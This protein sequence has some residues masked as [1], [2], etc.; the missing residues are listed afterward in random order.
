MT[1]P[2]WMSAELYRKKIKLYGFYPRFPVRKKLPRWDRGF[3]T[4]KKIKDI[5][6]MDIHTLFYLESHCLTSPSFLPVL[7]DFV[8]ARRKLTEFQ[9]GSSRLL[10]VYLAGVHKIGIPLLSSLEEKT[11]TTAGKRPCLPVPFAFI[12]AVEILKEVKEE[13]LDILRDPACA[14]AFIKFSGYVS[15]VVNK[16]LGDAGRKFIEDTIKFFFFLYPSSYLLS[17]P[18]KS[19]YILLYYPHLRLL[20]RYAI[21]QGYY[22][23][24]SRYLRNG[25]FETIINLINATRLRIMDF[26]LIKNPKTFPLLYY[27]KTKNIRLDEIIKIL[28][29][30]EPILPDVVGEYEIEFFRVALRIT[31]SPK[32]LLRLWLCFHFLFH[33]TCREN[34][35]KELVDEKLNDILLSLGLYPDFVPPG[36]SRKVVE[37][38]IKEGDNEIL[39]TM[40]EYAEAVGK[41]QEEREKVFF[42]LYRNTHVKKVKRWGDI[43]SSPPDSLRRF[44]LEHVDGVELG[45]LRELL[46]YA[47]FL[48]TVGLPVQ[49]RVESKI[50]RKRE[51]IECELLY[52]KRLSN[53]APHIKK[54]IENLER[55]LKEGIEEKRLTPRKILQKAASSL[56]K[57]L[58]QYLKDILGDVEELDRRWIAV[59]EILEKLNPRERKE[60]LFFL[61]EYRK[62]GIK[63]ILNYGDNP[64]IVEEMKKRTDSLDIWFGFSRR[65]NNYMVELEN[66][67]IEIINFGNYFY[68]C[69]STSTLRGA[70][71]A[72]FFITHASARVI[73]ARKGK[74]IA[75]RVVVWFTGSSLWHGEFKGK[76]SAQEALR[77][78]L[79]ELSIKMRLPIFPGPPLSGEALFATGGVY[80]SD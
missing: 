24:I 76:A 8:K 77:M 60:F 80:V 5:D 29:F 51:D 25:G 36:A 54:R 30:L 67:P 39:K 69:L 6:E 1:R 14:R 40:Y 44:I 57:Q 9:N 28:E 53:P 63:G 42:A 73:Y 72:W 59:F 34:L 58:H 35:S 17:H 4:R 49:I 22:H 27:L 70:Q 20:I 61:R 74:K 33:R 68:T 52:L 18:L 55:Y 3:F 21:K 62:K 10:F 65:I 50:K 64:F 48:K 41:T 43:P 16:I 45:V 37:I 32:T 13:Y 56:K 47:R 71:M 7:L 31:Q 79:Q 12:K 23:P 46:L 66:D 15:A 38:F 26:S 78:F 2:A 19:A 11:F 75:G